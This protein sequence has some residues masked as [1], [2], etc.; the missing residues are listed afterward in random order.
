MGNDT[1]N[2]MNNITLVTGLYDMGRD[3]LD[4][5]F[6]RDFTF[7]LERFT[8]L[9]NATLDYPMVIFTEPKVVPIVEQ[10]R[11]K[12]RTRIIT[13][14]SEEFKKWF[15]FTPQVTA[16]RS[17][18]SWYSQASWLQES[19]QAKL[20]LY[21]PFVLS[22]M[23][24]MSD[25]SIFNPFNT[26]YFL[27]V[28]AGITNTVHV[29]Y[30]SHDNILQKLP[31][32]L[33]PFL[34]LTF[35]YET[36]VEIH[37][38]QREELNKLANVSNVKFVCRGG[39][40]GGKKESIQKFNGIYYNLLKT[41]LNS[42]QLG[43]EESLFTALAYNYPF[44]LNLFALQE[45]G[46]IGYFCEAVKTGQGAFVNPATIR[47]I[48]NLTTTNHLES[49]AIIPSNDVA[50]YF[51]T[52]NFS[53]QLE[54]TLKTIKENQPEILNT[55]C[56][57][58][59]N[60]TDVVALEQN[61]E[62]AKR[63]SMRY[64]AHGNL[65]I[66]SGRF[67]CA[68]DFNQH[69]EYHYMLFFED[70]MTCCGPNTPPCKSG[71]QRYT[72]NLL[73]K[74][75]QILNKESLDFL[76]LTFSEFFGTNEHAW[77]WYNVPQEVRPELFPEQPNKLDGVPIPHTRFTSIKTYEEL[78]YALGLVHFCNWP[79]LLTKEG[80]RKIFLDPEFAYPQE[81]TMMSH[82]YQKQAKG[83]LFGGVLLAS[84]IEH[85]RFKFYPAE[86]RVECH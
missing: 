3:Q 59:D 36:G 21:L 71:F 81:A 6:K 5:M 23:F 51:L 28:D 2:L 43:T 84:P 4:P 31:I 73:R 47:P 40:F 65:G 38:Y 26:D 68:K 34:F 83:E 76:K 75:L 69:S 17:S 45:H 27:W 32:Y 64:E 66:C 72:Q 67:W 19:P 55:H 14:T 86:E 41:S 80:S 46:M 13:R 79:I 56:V 63:Y 24:M 12:S 57:L 1:G 16:I 42:G 62:I 52:F 78:P 20:D 30:F 53:D 22:K 7:Y 9:L 61:K 15:E 82:A 11:D 44:D 33:D 50:T 8:E 74:S 10:I 35:P 48:D 39:L 29:G 49:R 60:S 85:Y 25:S 58:L 77:A 54:H 70:D 37:G 18:E